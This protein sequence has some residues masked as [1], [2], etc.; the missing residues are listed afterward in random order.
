MALDT[1]DVT[2]DFGQGLEQ[3][4][5]SKRV[6][7]GFLT[8]ATNIL[9]TKDKQVRRRY[10]LS[11][12]AS[13]ANK[14]RKILPQPGTE[15]LGLVTD[16]A[17][18]TTT[19][20]LDVKV[21]AT[22]T[23]STVA[24]GLDGRSN[25]NDFS[26]QKI[27][28]ENQCARTAVAC[29]ST[30]V[31]QVYTAR[32][33]YSNTTTRDI[34][35]NVTEISTGR[36]IHRAVPLGVSATRYPR[37]IRVFAL[38][39]NSCYVYYLGGTNTVYRRTVTSCDTTPSVSS[40]TGVGT[41]TSADVYIDSSGSVCVATAT[42]NVVII[43]G[44][45]S[46]A[47]AANVDCIAICSEQGGNDTNWVVVAGLVDNTIQTIY[48]PKSGGSTLKL[49]AFAG[50]ATNTI[51]NSQIVAMRDVTNTRFA[52]AIS[53][54]M[55]TT[56][57]MVVGSS[58]ASSYPNSALTRLVFPRCRVMAG[59]GS[60]SEN[61]AN[62]FL[63][64]NATGVYAARQFTS[65]L[66]SGPTGATASAVHTKIAD[67]P[68]AWT[69]TTRVMEPS[70][71]APNSAGTG[72]YWAFPTSLYGGETYDSAHTTTSENE[73]YLVT[74]KKTDPSKN[75]RTASLG[76]ASY[77]VHS[78][79]IQVVEGS[80]YV[81]AALNA[82]PS[83]N[84]VTPSAAGS[85]TGTISVTA[86]LV[87]VDNKGKVIYGPFATP[88]SAVLS[89]NAT[90]TA[91]IG[92]PPQEK[93]AAYIE[94]YATDPNGSTYYRV[95]TT[96]IQD[97]N[98]I[99]WETTITI[100][101]GSVTPSAV[102]GTVLAYTTGGALEQNIPPS[103]K[104][105]T[106]ALGRLWMPS[107]DG[108]PSLFFSSETQETTSPRFN[109]VFVLQ[110]PSASTEVLHAV[111][112]NQR[113]VVFTSQEVFVVSGTG[114][115]LTGQGSAFTVDL[116]SSEHGAANQESVVLTGNSILFIQSNG[117]VWELAQDLSFAYIG[118]AVEDAV[119]AT[120]WN[121][122]TVNKT[123]QVATLLMNAGTCL[124]YDWYYKQWYSSATTATPT[125]V[126]VRDDGKESFL[127]SDG[128][129]QRILL[130]DS[131]ATTDI[132]SAG[133]AVDYSFTMTT[134][135][136][137]FA[138]VDGLQRVRYFDL[139]GKSEVTGDTT[140]TVSIAH[141]YN[142]TPSETHTVTLTAA[143]AQDATTL[144]ARIFLTNQ[145]SRAVKISITQGTNPANWGNSSL[146]AM[147]FRLGVKKKAA[148]ANEDRRS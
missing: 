54:N 32:S 85:L 87:T 3:K 38:S 117:K 80:G 6:Q 136:L 141:N 103:P 110:I 42:T 1:A 22:G 88:V 134:G 26:Y 68:A 36:E 18:G 101:S 51:A 121:A 102:T 53:V 83:I 77:I 97:P 21:G 75:G 93:V 96:K 14:V 112:F 144:L 106:S 39:A 8:V 78:G 143:T 23:V 142:E 57:D 132:N 43:N 138:E 48:K 131:T 37:C 16:T 7:L 115:G 127:I 28:K 130:S 108:T 13:T 20:V 81:P 90:V 35:L 114:P 17:L 146:T 118:R 133:A 84:T 135:W 99:T 45:A 60:T 24:E 147:T 92:M 123:K 64:Q 62:F 79:K 25:E 95:A 44:S 2:I 104:W 4:A 63:Y 9:F 30:L 50:V 122:F 31:F 61:P 120:N 72:G 40:E 55:A 12:L 139:Q 67:I 58:T 56:Q 33:D 91:V 11:Q 89:S 107:V 47:L 74:M 34:Y 41:G 71:F 10:G 94:I 82:V 46:A 27:T 70:P 76:G 15:I 116:L 119:T 145:K 105:V 19:D 73:V 111:E 86:C 100:I 140:L 125:S 29:S 66:S 124:H 52:Y 5:D 65:R 59:F 69:T 49:T 126:C 129:T 113:L 128:T 137:N 98:L 109:P 148:P